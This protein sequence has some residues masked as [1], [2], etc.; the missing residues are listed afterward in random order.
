MQ[1]NKFGLLKKNILQP[2]CVLKT[3]YIKFVVFEVETTR[4]KDTFVSALEKMQLLPSEQR[5]KLIIFVTDEV[6][7]TLCIDRTAQGNGSKTTLSAIVADQLHFS[8][9]ISSPLGSCKLVECQ[10]PTRIALI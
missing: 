4:G 5:E 7:I 3:C 6:I 10:G 1:I 9:P 2:L 8:F